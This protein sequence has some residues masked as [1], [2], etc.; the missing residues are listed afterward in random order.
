MADGRFVALSLKPDGRLRAG[1]ADRDRKAGCFDM[2]SDGD[3][4]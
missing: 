1:G 4:V 2:R 3:R